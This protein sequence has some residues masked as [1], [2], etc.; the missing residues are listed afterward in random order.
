MEKMNAQLVSIKRS[1]LYVVYSK[2]F[3]FFSQVC[4]LFFRGVS[5]TFFAQNRIFHFGRE[6]NVQT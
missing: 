2:F 5:T 1:S 6:L 3:S 4:H